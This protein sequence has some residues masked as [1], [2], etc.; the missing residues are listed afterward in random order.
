MTNNSSSRRKTPGR[1]L[2][3]ALVALTVTGLAYSDE[4]GAA[5]AVGSVTAFAPEAGAVLN[6]EI[7]TWQGELLANRTAAGYTSFSTAGAA[8]GSPIAAG[9]V[10]TSTIFN[11]QLTWIDSL[12][13]VKSSN[14]GGLVTTLGTVPA[15]SD[16]ML[17][18]ADAIFLRS[19]SLRTPMDYQIVALRPGAAAEGLQARLGG[20][21]LRWDEVLRIIGP[22]SRP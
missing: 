17:T 18:V 16:S 1:A 2:T 10:R 7:I 6:G 11:G 3:C 20:A 21:L 13:A 8:A 14:P 22:A 12:N 4:A 5:D 15:G 19:D 9:I